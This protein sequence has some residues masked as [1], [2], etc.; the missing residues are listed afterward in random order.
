MAQVENQ[1]SKVMLDVSNTNSRTERLKQIRDKLDE[2][3]AAKNDI[4]TKS[5]NEI[6]RRNAIIER[7]QGV[8]D[9]HNK[10]LE[11]MIQAAGVSTL[12]LSFSSG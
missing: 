6:V 9:Q 3:I 11:Q 1:I 10:K 2:E 7:K 4:I 8:I 12:S 5:E